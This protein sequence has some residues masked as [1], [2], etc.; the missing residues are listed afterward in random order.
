[1]ARPKKETNLKAMALK[2]HQELT[3]QRK[4][5]EDELKSLSKYLKA[6][7]AVKA[8]RG[9]PGKAAESKKTSATESIVSAISGSKQ[10]ISIDQIMKQTGFG[11]QTVNGVLNRMKKAGKVKSAG[12]GVYVKA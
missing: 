10:G 2:R 6:V 12:R 1:M 5:I 7:G 8:K 3:S 9:R 4:E 11:R